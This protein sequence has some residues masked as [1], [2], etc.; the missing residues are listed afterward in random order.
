MLHASLMP[1]LSNRSIK[2]IK[3]DDSERLTRHLVEFVDCVIV[4]VWLWWSSDSWSS[5]EC[6]LCDI[7]MQLIR[8]SSCASIC[9]KFS[10][11]ESTFLKGFC[12]CEDLFKG[13]LSA[14][15][16]LRTIGLPI[17]LL[18][19]ANRVEQDGVHSNLVISSCINLDL[20]L[21]P[22][23]Y[24]VGKTLVKKL[25]YKIFFETHKN[26]KFIVQETW[27]E[28]WSKEW[29]PCTGYLRPFPDT[30]GWGVWQPTIYQVDP[31][32]Y[33]LGITQPTSLM[34]P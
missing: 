34:W 12:V 20:P 13:F 24:R 27:N 30:P 31:P 1:F 8:F 11:C 6:W 5:G 19:A 16:F 9:L 2:S 10:F 4:I 32:S 26:L 23:H 28:V 25:I 18:L 29:K 33:Q 22:L 3:S 17:G 21:L 7:A 14:R 15:G